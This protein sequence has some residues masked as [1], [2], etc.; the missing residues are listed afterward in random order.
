MGDDRDADQQRVREQ[1]REDR[2]DALMRASRVVTAAIV[3]SLTHTRAELSITQLRVLVMLAARAPMSIGDVA[4]E[5]EVNA[6]NASRT[7]D[8]LVGRGLL[9]RRVADEDRRQVRLD[10]TARGQALVDAVLDQRRRMFAA[11]LDEM[12]APAQQR[13]LGALEEFSAAAGRVAL[14]RPEESGDEHLMAWMR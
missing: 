5:L 14:I 13:L 8:R 12:P 4:A 7:C 3:R 10:L 2:L 11:V 6:S 9:E 1:A